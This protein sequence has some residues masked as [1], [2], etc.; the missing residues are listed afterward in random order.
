M[1]L[2]LAAL[3]TPRR[4][5]LLGFAL[6]LL[7][8]IWNGFFGPSFGAEGDA[9]TFHDAAVA[10]SRGEE[11]PR[12]GVIGWSYAYV[13]G[14]VYA[15]IDDSV[16]VGS[17]LSC[18]AWLASA[19]LL[20]KSM[21]ILAFAKAQQAKALAVFAFLPSSILFT[22]VTL[23]EPYQLLAVNL[24]VFAALKI[25]IEKRTLYW[26]PLFAAAV[27][28]GV[29]HMV[30]VAFAVYFPAATFI[31]LMLRRHRGWT[32]RRL[33]FMVSLLGAALALTYVIFNQVG[34]TLERGLIAGVEEFQQ[35]ALTIDARTAYKSDV[36]VEGV[37]DFLLF[38]LV[39]LLQYLFEPLPWRTLQP[40]DLVT[41]AENVVR[42]GLL[43]LALA[44]VRGVPS[45][46]R[47]AAEFIVLSFLVLETFW[48]LG[49][50]NWGTAVR[51]HIPALG[52]L[53]LGAFAYSG[54]LRTSTVRRA[55]VA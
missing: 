48:C 7:V 9:I 45:A 15:L 39:S 41:I 55:A 23:R 49:T 24:A 32:P 51:H 8:A 13:L 38:V 3:W 18:I 34:F 33:A 40:T 5:I 1:R 16:F 43:C 6:R 28:A 29:L 46:S 50:T 25:L 10:F 47:G 37:V 52:L 27:A 11:V 17:L 14:L 12:F 26:V 19:V 22:G 53:M 31:F 35:R 21:R 54:R 42:G 44:T 2:R 4:L 30:L 36:H 20:R